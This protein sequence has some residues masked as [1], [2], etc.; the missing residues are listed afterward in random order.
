M[1]SKEVHNNGRKGWR[2]HKGRSKAD[3]GGSCLRFQNG[4][5]QRTVFD[6]VSTT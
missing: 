2:L 3:F 4:W 5:D 6:K 1:I